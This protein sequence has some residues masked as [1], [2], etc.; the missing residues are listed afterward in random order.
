MSRLMSIVIALLTTF[1]VGAPASASE[2]PVVLEFE[3]QWAAPDY[4]VGTV[5]GGGTLEMWLFDKSVIGN[6]QHFSAT[7]GVAS[8]IASLAAVVSGQIDFSTGRVFLNGSVTS[9]PWAGA[10]VHEESVLVD[11]TTGRFTGSIRIMPASSGQGT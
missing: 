3:K 4:Y 11:P 8:P 9:G 5:A 1:L 2:R 6:T 10:R 7:V